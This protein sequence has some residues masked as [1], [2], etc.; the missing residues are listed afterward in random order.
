VVD[1]AFAVRPGASIKGKKIILVDDVLTT[2]ATAEAC[3]KALR[4][5]GAAGVEL[6]AFA[7]VLPDR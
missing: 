3:A 5:A 1:G 2:G 7:R 6:I 4:K